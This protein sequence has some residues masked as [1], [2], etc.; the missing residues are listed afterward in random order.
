MKVKAS[1]DQIH[2]ALEKMT[3]ASLVSTKNRAVIEGWYSQ[4]K[5]DNTRVYITAMLPADVQMALK[6]NTLPTVKEDK[7]PAL[8]IRREGKVY[9][10]QEEKAFAKAE[11]AKTYV[12]H[13]EQAG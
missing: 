2:T 3:G 12:T 4:F 5:P 10:E 9:R 7:L 1:I 11:L 8:G 13:M 6:A